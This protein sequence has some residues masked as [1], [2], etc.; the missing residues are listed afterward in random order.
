MSL[1]SPPAI[2]G[3]AGM[4]RKFYTSAGVEGPSFTPSPP[5]Y[6]LYLFV[7]TYKSPRGSGDSFDTIL[8]QKT[9]T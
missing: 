3:R 5:N 1:E 4:K 7:Y 9:Q 8:Y 2:R 6:H